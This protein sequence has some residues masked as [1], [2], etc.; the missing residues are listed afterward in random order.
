[1]RDSRD[2]IAEARALVDHLCSRACAGREPG[3]PQGAA[4][5]ARIAAELERIGIL[6]A[7][8][9]GF[10]QS[11]PGCRGANVLG[12][13]PGR[14][15]LAERVVLVAAHYDHLGEIDEHDAYWGADDNAAAIA[16][17]VDVAR[18]LAGRAG[19]LDREVWFA[20][21]DAEE[22]PYFLSDAMGSVHFM[23]TGL[24]ARERLDMMVCM[25]L[26][27]HALGTPE[28]PDEVRRSFF[29]LG[30][31]RS[32]GTRSIVDEA[33]GTSRKVFPRRLASDVL[34][35]LSDYYAFERARVPFL[36]LTCGRWEHY[37]EPTDTP[38]KLD[39]EKI[40]AS[41]DYLADLV[42][43]MSQRPDAPVVYESGAR[44]DDSTL[45]SIEAVARLLVP[46]LAEAR[47][48][49]ERIERLR[50]KLASR[51]KLGNSDRASITTLLLK[52]EGLVAKS[53]P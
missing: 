43:R 13:I 35:A 4:A 19:E 53:G 25:D 29:V 10:L 15:L 20:A 17:L 30:A 34:P 18:A 7:G 3:T 28:L 31:E 21:F 12:R 46:H 26:M 8:S 11:V 14:G 40:I 9:D 38:E 6:P 48:V 27:G 32:A 5:R 52:M 1:M 47:P 39:Y 44:D 22:P 45:S 33:G 50:S 24:L 2:R 36:F 49:A 23:N 37:H 41:A 51:G 16:I 42:L